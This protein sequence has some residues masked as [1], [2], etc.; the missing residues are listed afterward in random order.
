MKSTA[1]KGI[2]NT[3]VMIEPD[4][5]RFKS[6]KLEGVDR[7]DRGRLRAALEQMPGNKLVIGA[8]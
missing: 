2:M 7:N 3:D 5:K 4:L 8:K 6:T 1:Y